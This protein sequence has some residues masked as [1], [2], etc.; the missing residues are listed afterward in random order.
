MTPQGQRTAA[1]WDQ[2][3]LKVSRLGASCLMYN[4]YVWHCMLCDFA[5]NVNL[6]V[7]AHGPTVVAL[8]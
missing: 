6:T 3:Q 8:A 7:S 4:I 1:E 2:H 5:S